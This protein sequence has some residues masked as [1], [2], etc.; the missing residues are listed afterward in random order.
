MVQAAMDS[1]QCPGLYLL[2][3][4]G[5]WNVPSCEY[6]SSSTQAR[7]SRHTGGSYALEKGGKI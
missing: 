2:K 5:T 1:F 6:P 7:H 3:R 4:H